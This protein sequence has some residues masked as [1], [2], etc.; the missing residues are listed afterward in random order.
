MEDVEAKVK[1]VLLEILDIEP[2]EVDPQ[3]AG[4][5]LVANRARESR[6]D[7]AVSNSFGFGGVNTCIV[8]KR[9]PS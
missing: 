4:I 3:C 9:Y 6:I 5:N 2:E 8:V 7:I 1:E